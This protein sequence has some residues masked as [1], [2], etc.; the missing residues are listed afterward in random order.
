MGLLKNKVAII[1]GASSGI[2]CA[3]AKLFAHEGA[4]VI[5]GVR[6]EKELNALV[7]E[8]VSAGGQVKALAGDV[9]DEDYN[10]TLV[11][12]AVSEYGQLDIAFNNAGMLG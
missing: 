5:M 12:L 8:I 3:S 7:E 2:R 1:T 11:D 6:R 10:K 4:K 9:K